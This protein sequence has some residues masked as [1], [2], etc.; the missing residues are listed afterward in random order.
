MIIIIILI[1]FF[2]FIIITTTIAPSQRIWLSGQA[3]QG[4]GGV[5]NLG[6]DTTSSQLSSSP[7]PSSSSSSSSPGVSGGG[8]HGDGGVLDLGELGGDEER[9]LHLHTHALAAV[10]RVQRLREQLRD[11]QTRGSIP[12][13]EVTW[14]SE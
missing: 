1:F 14:P 5:L 10:L 2:F 4:D 12:S 11:I 3:G 9:R 6:D 7:S 13:V 8:G